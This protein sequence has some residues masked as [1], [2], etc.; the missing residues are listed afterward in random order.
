MTITEVIKNLQEI[1]DKHGDLDV[2]VV[3]SE[4][5]A[6]LVETF[7]LQYLLFK[8]WTEDKSQPPISVILRW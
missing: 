4:Y 3:D 8:D 2:R 7:E 5:C 6:P 1:K